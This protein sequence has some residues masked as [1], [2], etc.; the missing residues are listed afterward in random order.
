MNEALISIGCVSNIYVRQMH[1]V[2]AGDVEF[3]HSHCFDHLSLLAKGKVLCIVNDKETEF[4]APAMIFIKKDTMHEFVS[5]EN[6]SLIYCIHAIRNGDS[7][8]DIIDPNSIPEGSSILDYAK[9]VVNMVSSNLVIEKEIQRHETLL[10]EYK[11]TTCDI[12]I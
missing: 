1:F 4:C 7:V 5:L 12:N 2:N 11:T 10:S 9:P 3:G 6:D 8:E